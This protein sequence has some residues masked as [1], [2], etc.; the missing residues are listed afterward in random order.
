MSEQVD[1]REIEDKVLRRAWKARTFR[2]YYGAVGAEARRFPPRTLDVSVT[3]RMVV[4]PPP[5][6][7]VP[8]EDGKKTL[9]DLVELLI[10]K[11]QA[12]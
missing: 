3:G 11:G 1:Y 4:T 2:D 8:R 10:E 5:L 9:A 7:T 12:K 6:R